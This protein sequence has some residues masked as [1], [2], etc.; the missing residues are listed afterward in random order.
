[1][2]KLLPKK[3]HWKAQWTIFLYRKVWKVGEGNSA[4]LEQWCHW[5]LECH[6]KK[7]ITLWHEECDTKTAGQFD[8]LPL[9]SQYHC[10]KNEVRGCQ[11]H[12]VQAQVSKARY[13][14]ITLRFTTKEAILLQSEVNWVSFYFFSEKLEDYSCT[15]HRKCQIHVNPWPVVTMGWWEHRRIGNY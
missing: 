10:W 13:I 9:S 6:W 12:K 5:F 4:Q 1:M 14:R 11:A 7:V 3:T 2:V 8:I 15:Y